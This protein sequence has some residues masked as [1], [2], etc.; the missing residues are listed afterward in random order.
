[1]ICFELE[2]IFKTLKENNKTLAKKAKDIL[3]KFD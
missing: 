3:N 1:M 2:K